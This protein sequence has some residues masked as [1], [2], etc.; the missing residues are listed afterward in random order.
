MCS[1]AEGL[2]ISPAGREAIDALFH[3]VVQVAMPRNPG[4]HALPKAN[5]W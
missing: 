5:A 4:L 1:I 2:D 3:A